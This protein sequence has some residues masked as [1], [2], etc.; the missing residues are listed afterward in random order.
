M[1]LK[2]KWI[3]SLIT[4]L[5]IGVPA[6]RATAPEAL[7]RDASLRR[8][9]T[10]RV[11]AEAQDWR[12]RPA[13]VPTLLTELERAFDFAPRHPQ[14]R[15]KLIEIL[16]AQPL[17]GLSPQEQELHYSRLLS[18]KPRDAG[19][20]LKISGLQ[21]AKHGAHAEQIRQAQ[22]R[23]NDAFNLWDEHQYEAALR[24]LRQ[25]VLPHSSELIVL[26]AQHLRD[27]GQIQEARAVLQQWSAKPDYLQLRQGLLQKLKTA[28]IQASGR[29][30]T[31]QQA[32][33]LIDIGQYQAA[34]AILSQQ[35]ESALKH[36]YQAKALEKQAYYHEAA[37]HY[38]HY[39]RLKWGGQ[40][41][42][43]VPVVYKV[44]LED[45]N[46][47]ALVALKFRTSPELIRKLNENA[48]EDWLETYRM[49]VIPVPRRGMVWPTT[50]Y[51]S[52]HFGWRLHPIRAVWKLHEGLD[53]ET[54]PGVRAFA[55]EAGQVVQ[56]AYD[57]GCGVMIRLQHQPDVHTVYCHGEKQLAAAGAQLSAGSPVLITGNTGASA[58][59]H[60]HF[61]VKFKGE[62]TDPM[63][64]L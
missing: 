7:A 37:L 10:N 41:P 24:L 60:L 58:S 62:Y 59:N 43:F 52:S 34:E 27:R 42:D 20:R 36:W 45:L 32:G 8:T 6:A 1:K 19:L 23:L 18:L 31:L 13:A 55:A 50:G 39:Y 17:T 22:T 4:P 5:M 29:K 3:L 2:S 33:A 12:R 54:R 56:R 44:Q 16:E 64:W 48:A 53:I 26:L 30:N 25:A 14:L 21:A 57:K 61:G 28:E 15:Q 47:L 49:V 63:D 51:V 35:P 46:S 40:Y 9:F 38:Q 11:L